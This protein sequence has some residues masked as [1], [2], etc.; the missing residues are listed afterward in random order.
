MLPV[1]ALEGRVGQFKYLFPL[2]NQLQARRSKTGC[3]V[4]GFKA[5]RLISVPTFLY[6]TRA[7]G[8]LTWAPDACEI[9]IYGKL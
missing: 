8:A 1:A 3:G 4:A 7:D 2:V 5:S 9:K 6:R